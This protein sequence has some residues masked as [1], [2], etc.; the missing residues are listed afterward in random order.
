MRIC[1]CDDHELIAEQLSGY[2]HTFFKRFPIKN[3]DI[4]LFGDGESLLKDSG[5]KDILFLDIEMP[6][7]NGIYVGQTLKKEYKNIII[8]VVTS[9]AEYLDEAMRFHVFRYLSKP[10]EKQRLFR[11]LKDAIQLYNTTTS[12]LLIETKDS[13]HTVL[14]N[15]I[16]LVEAD[17][18][19]VLIHTINYKYEST[20]NMQYWLQTLPPGS[21]FQSHRSF[22]IN[23]TYV[24]EFNHN[25][26]HLYNSESTAYLT[27]RK[28]ADFKNAY[29][30]YL[31]ST[32]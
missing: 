22:I 16:V 17:A 5:Q 1:I 2:I 12:T 24:T 10:V 3:Y 20:Q 30:L 26:I 28:Y 29:L 25:I 27:R 8:F 9:Y 31:E 15:H 21:F 13:V 19:K 23:F 14:T 4:S 11:N 7:M 32:R 18:R 6:N